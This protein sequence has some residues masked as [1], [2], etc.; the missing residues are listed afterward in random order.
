MSYKVELVVFDI[1]G[2]TVKDDG[3]VS[4]AFQ[5]AMLKFGYT[6]SAQ[7]VAPLMGY[8]KVDAIRMLLDKNE[9]NR[10]NVTDDLV[11]QIHECFLDEM[12][13]FYMESYLPEPLPYVEDVFR[14]LH[15][16]GIRTALDTGFPKR[17][18]EIV[19]SKLNWLSNGLVDCAISSDQV[20]AGRPYPYM[21]EAIMATLSIK[22]PKR[23]IKI[24]DTSVDI[25]EGKAA[26]CLY[27]IGITTGTFSKMELLKSDPDFVLDAMDELLEVIDHH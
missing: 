4:L 10:Q 15:E 25:K 27:S 18:T 7:Q 12:S 21:I 26:N 5:N 19:L 2:T 24:G 22:D 20:K 9:L 13:S 14:R 3:I 16:R 23:V 1:A 6:F 8:K 11:N 17:I